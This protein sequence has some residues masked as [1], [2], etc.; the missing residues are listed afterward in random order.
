MKSLRRAWYFLRLF[1]AAIRLQRN[2]EQ[3]NLVFDIGDSLYALGSM[4]EAKRI[5]E[6]NPDFQSIIKRRVLVE[7]Y[8]LK[9]LALL[10]PGTLGYVY[11]QHMLTNKLD[12]DFYRRPKTMTDE[13][14]F[15]L[16]VRQTHDLWHVVTGF[17]TSVA[18]ELSLQAFTL[19]QLATPLSM[20]LISFSLFRLTFNQQEQVVEFMNSI[21]KGWAMGRNS[22]ALFAYDWQS[23]FQKDLLQVRLELGLPA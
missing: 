17:D 9:E 2:P 6:S 23:A 11:A 13:T 19:A 5:V 3:T 18:G 8:S 1:G 12:P 4:Q 21:T 10:A 14:Y 15:F 22:K 7:G 16:R 20:I